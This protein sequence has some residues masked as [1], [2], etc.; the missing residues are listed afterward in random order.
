MLEQEGTFYNRLD[1]SILGYQYYLWKDRRDLFFNK[2]DKIKNGYWA[3]KGEVDLNLIID[4]RKYTDK[5]DKLV[6][7]MRFF[8]GKRAPTNKIY[9]DLVKRRSYLDLNIEN[10]EIFLRDCIIEGVVSEWKEPSHS[11]NVLQHLR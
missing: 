10:E 1:N 6:F 7:H 9:M 5:A 2:K 4:N 3:T 11:F 8:D